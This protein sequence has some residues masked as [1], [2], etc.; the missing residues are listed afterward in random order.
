MEI[1]E[2]EKEVLAGAG[3]SCSFGFGFVVG[4]WKFIRHCTV[5]LHLILKL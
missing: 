3:Y 1:Y 4:A 2:R 5:Y